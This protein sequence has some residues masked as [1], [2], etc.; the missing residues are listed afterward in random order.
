MIEDLKQKSKF[1]EFDL[2]T[3]QWFDISYERMNSLSQIQLTTWITQAKQILQRAKKNRNSFQ[4]PITRFFQST[5]TNAQNFSHSTVNKNKRNIHT[6]SNDKNKEPPFKGKKIEK[7]IHQ[8]SK[9]LHQIL[10]KKNHQIPHICLYRH[11]I[12]KEI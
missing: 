2:I 4:Q 11:Q 5:Q 8:S 1:F 10:Q 7:K 3:R 6:L 9:L 12:R